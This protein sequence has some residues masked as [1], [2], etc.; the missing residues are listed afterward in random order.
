[1]RAHSGFKFVLAGG[2]I[3]LA[4]ATAFIAQKEVFVVARAPT[5]DAQAIIEQR[6]DMLAYSIQ[7][8]YAALDAC[9]RVAGSV[10]SLL[11]PSVERQTLAQACQA[12]AKSIAKASPQNAYAWFTLAYFSQVIGQQEAM[13]R[14]LERS[15]LTGPNE[16]WIA[17]QRVLLAEK[18]L[19]ALSSAALSGH[20]LDLALLV[21]SRRGIGAIAQR[22]VSDPSFRARITDIVEGLSNDDQRRFLAT[23]QQEVRGK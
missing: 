16:Q 6:E 14:A 20:M 17:E 3:I 21:Q 23:L 4:V 11:S 10:Q 18:M 15:Y 7:A 22:Y 5:W 13:T 8:D 1:M 19:P 12:I 9:L 2:F